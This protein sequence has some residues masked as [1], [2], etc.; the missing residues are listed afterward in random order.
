MLFSVEPLRLRQPGGARAGERLRER[1][2]GRE[3][4]RAEGGAQ[5]QLAVR[6]TR[7][8]RRNT[9]SPTSAGPTEGRQRRWSRRKQAPRVKVVSGPRGPGKHQILESCRASPELAFARKRTEGTGTEKPFLPG[10]GA[11]NGRGAPDAPRILV[12]SVGSS[13]P[14]P[15]ILQQHWRPGSRAGGGTGAMFSGRKTSSA[16]SSCDTEGV[17]PTPRAVFSTVPCIGLSSPQTAQVQP[18][19][20]HSGVARGPFPPRGSEGGGERDARK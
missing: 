1:P 16:Q 8:V 2:K 5:L 7:E 17:G 9:P 4:C 11:R 3:G 18:S 12:P 19:S 15:A 20:W 6:F 14:G 13:S 10:T